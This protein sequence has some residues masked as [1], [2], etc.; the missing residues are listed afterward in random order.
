MECRLT[1]AR[2]RLADLIGGHEQAFAVSRAGRVKL[3]LLG[4]RSITKSV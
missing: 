3:A 1:R 2:Q 4:V